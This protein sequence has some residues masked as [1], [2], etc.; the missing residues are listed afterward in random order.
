MVIIIIVIIIFI[1]CVRVVPV[2]LK[3]FVSCKVIKS[4]SGE[5]RKTGK[6]EPRGK[7]HKCSHKC[8]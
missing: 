6:N 7:R 8:S 1:V 2:K 3:S 5:N 4:K